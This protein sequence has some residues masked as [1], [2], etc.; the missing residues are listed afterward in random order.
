MRLLFKHLVRSMGKKPL[1]PIILVFTIALAVSTAIFAF[2]VGDTLR[3]DIEASQVAKYGNA[4]LTVSVG[5]SSDSR[6]L[7]ADDVERLLDDRANVAGAYELP[8]ILGDS[9]K[10]VVG[11]ATEFDSVCT[12]FYFEFVEYGR[13]TEGSLGDVAFIS[14]KLAKEMDLSVGDTLEVETM[15]HTRTYRIEGISKNSFLGSYDVMVDICSVMRIFADNS[16]VFAAIGDDFKPCSKIYVDLTECDG[17]D[18]ED[19]VTLLSA[20]PRFADKTFTDVRGIEGR[21]VRSGV[22]DLIVDFAVALAVLLS[23]VITFCCFYI[24]ANE[25]AEE[26]LVLSF[27]GARP[28]VLGRMQYAETLI[29][30]LFG[31]PLGLLGAI[32]LTRLISHFVPLKY[33]EVSIRPITVLKSVLVVLLGCSL[34]V[35][36]FLLTNKR[37]RRTGNKHKLAGFSSTVGLLIALGLLFGA[38]YLLTPVIRFLLY[39]I[40]VAVLVALIFAVVPPLLQR[41]IFLTDK[42]SRGVASPSALAFRYAL[43]NVCS[44]KL[45]HNIARLCALIVAIVLTIGLMFACVQ[46]HISLI[47][48]AFDADYAVLNATDSCY[49]KVLACEGAG[50]VHKFHLTN[51]DLTTIVSADDVSA[52]SE[53]LHIE[54]LPVGNEAMV[55]SGIANMLDIEIGDPF[56]ITLDGQDYELVL[57]GIGKSGTNYVAINCEDLGVPYNMIL[58]KGGESVSRADL[59][60]SLSEATSTELTAIVSVDTLFENLIDSMQIYMSAGKILLFIFVVFSLIGVADALYESARARREEFGLYRLAGMSPR[61]LR[62]MKT[63]EF[64]IAIAFGIAIGLLIF[65][66]SAFASNQ[67]MTGRGFELFLGLKALLTAK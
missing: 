23:A 37:L 5:N 9:G 15:G 42:R 64:A 41:L 52:F 39:I 34:T 22:V 46:G 29:Y 26:N 63:A 56:S 11:M 21:M 49:E 3:D 20:D 27:S 45:F 2:T 10:T 61:T 40:T 14:S 43:K 57:A 1:Q 51:S 4:E 32:P 12:V 48:G 7:F 33:I 13:V 58:V 16:L 59:L 28:K 25:R 62:R 47:E 53:S 50:S 31:A 67:G 66:I 17:L 54:R 35:A 8:L 19:A 24:L 44:L 60:A 38:M 18:V 55:S 30:W 6:F 65:V 36:F